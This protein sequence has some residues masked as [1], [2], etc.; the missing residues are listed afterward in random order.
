MEGFKK[1]KLSSEDEKLS[2][3]EERSLTSRRSYYYY[4]YYYYDY[5]YDYYYYYG[6]YY[7]YSS[8]SSS[9]SE[10]LD[11]EYAYLTYQKDLK[12]LKDDV[13]SS[14]NR[15]LLIMLLVLIVPTAI[16]MFVVIFMVCLHC[17]STPP[18]AEKYK[19]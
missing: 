4:D 18:K 3:L 14:I 6:Y 15:A 8:S 12:N 9:E 19:D 16:F 2:E 13:D 17:R 10:Y 1:N 7:Y 11:F 5:Y